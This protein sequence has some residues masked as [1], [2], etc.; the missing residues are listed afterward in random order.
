MAV[1]ISY[2]RDGTTLARWAGSEEELRRIAEKEKQKPACAK[3]LLGTKQIY[4]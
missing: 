4:P 3:I 2:K 1:M